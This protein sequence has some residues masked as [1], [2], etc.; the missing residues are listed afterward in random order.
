MFA[1]EYHCLLGNQTRT[2]CIKYVQYICSE[3]ISV[4]VCVH[5]CVHTCIFIKR[6]FELSVYRL[7][8]ISKSHLFKFKCLILCIAF[9]Q[10]LRSQIKLKILFKRSH[11]EKTRT[12]N[13]Y[14]NIL[15]D[16]IA[17]SIGS[18]FIKKVI[19]THFL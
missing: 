13:S 10:S 19:D 12:C 16:L 18:T 11:T 5:V 2:W 7:L 8:S 1:F 3:Y 17:C 14:Y 6:N 15:T 9:F 4:G